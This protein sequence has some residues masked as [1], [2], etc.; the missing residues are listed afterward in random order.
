[1]SAEPENVGRGG[2]RRVDQLRPHPLAC[3]VP[4]LAAGEYDA[5]KA[6]IAAHGM[7]VAI[8]ITEEGLV[9]DG[10]GRLRAARELGIEEVDVQVV[11]PRDELEHILRAALLRRQLS[12]SQRAAVA[13]KLAAVDELSA[14]AKQRSLANLRRGPEMATLP[15]RGEGER[16]RDLVAKLAGTAART[17]QDVLTVHAADPT[18]FE[19]VLRGELSA[20][21]A[22]SKVRRAK[23]DAAIPPAPP[24]PEG[25]FELIL[26]DPPWSYGSPDSP[27]APEQHYPTMTH[28]ELRAIELPATENCVLFLWAVNALL[29]EAL[30]LLTAWGFRY[31]SNLT[32]VKPSIG[33]GVW[34]RQR[35]EILLIATRGTVPPPDP[36]DR[37]DSVIE[38]PRGRHSEK[39]EI[40]YQRIEQ[41]FPDKTKLELFARGKPRPGWVAWGNESEPA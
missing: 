4:P 41:M 22:A 7:Q 34:L 14:A 16:T 40:A 33:P 13:T 37:C 15:A 26:A 32:W 3:E 20:N 30:E 21:T 36:E 8:Q 5:V 25:P 2:R 31:R 35:H 23:R 9:L 10:H 28:A 1:V 24:L 19:R 38:A 11:T 29:P 6:D 39:P 12:P 27:L 18:L 17:A